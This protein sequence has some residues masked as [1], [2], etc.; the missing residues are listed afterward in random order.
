[1]DMQACYEEYAKTAVFSGCSEEKFQELA[2]LLLDKVYA[3]HLPQTKSARILEVGC[4]HGRFLS[5]LLKRGYTDVYGI[6]FSSDQIAYAK[7]KLQLSSQVEQAEAIGFLQK[8]AA[9]HYDCILLLDVMEHLTV[10]DSIDLVKQFYR[11]LR[12]QGKV[13]IQV[14][15]ALTPLAP[16]RHGDLTHYRAYTPKTLGQTL[17]LGGFEAIHYFPI[18]PV[19]KGWKSLIRSWIWKGMINPFLNFYMLVALGERMGGIYTPNLL[20]VAMK[21]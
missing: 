1:M 4:G 13:I 18:P 7:E 8:A 21:K 6:D 9:D 3:S 19:V 16:Y 2:E 10:A 15:N 5:A 11:V 12:P 20:T 17:L 14:P